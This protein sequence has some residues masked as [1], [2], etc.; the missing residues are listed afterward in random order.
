MIVEKV[1]KIHHKFAVIILLLV[2]QQVLCYLTGFFTGY[3]A[4]VYRQLIPISFGFLIIALIGMWAIKQDSKETLAIALF[5]GVIALSC[6]LIFGLESLQ[7]HK[8]PPDLFYISYGVSISLLLYLLLDKISAFKKILGNKAILWISLCSIEL[9]YWHIP[10]AELLV[11]LY[12]KANWI[13]MYAAVLLIAFALTLLQTRLV[14][15]LYGGNL[16][17]KT[18]K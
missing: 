8:Y 15:D 5:F 2:V 10:F 3:S 13:V 9:F 1:D 11:D 4:Q 6:I 16:K 18:K 14:P 7:Q 12:P 17:K